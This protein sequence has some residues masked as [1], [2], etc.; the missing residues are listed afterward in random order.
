MNQKSLYKPIV[1]IILDGWGLT[2]S[3]SG[4]FIA[5]GQPRNFNY[6]WRNYPHQSLKSLAMVSSDRDTYP[7]SEICHTII[8]AGRLV[9][10]ISGIIS[11]QIKSGEFYQNQILHKIALNIFNAKTNLHLVGMITKAHS[12]AELTHLQALLNYFKNKGVK[13]VYLHGILD[14]VDTNHNAGIGT[15]DWLEKTLESQ[16]LGK[17]ATLTGRGWIEDGDAD[18]RQ[19]RISAR[20]LFETNK[21]PTSPNPLQAIKNSY[22]NH[23]GDADFSP[24]LMLNFDPELSRIK[25]DD[26]IIFFNFNGRDISEYINIISNYNKNIYTLTDYSHLKTQPIFTTPKVSPTL[27]EVISKNNLKIAKITESYKEK[28]L[29]YDFNG[30]SHSKFTGEENFILKSYTSHD[31][32]KSPQLRL[33]DVK[34][35]VVSKIVQGNFNLIVTNLP[36]VDICG[37]TGNSQ[38]VETAVKY[39]D[40]AI[41]EIVEKTLSVGGC[42]ILTADHGLAEEMGKI[43]SFTGQLKNFHTTNP[44]PFILINPDNRLDQHSLMQQVDRGSIISAMMGSDYNLADI[45]PTILELLGL[46][47]PAEMTGKSLLSSLNKN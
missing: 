27:S 33:Y 3:W 4:N 8:G 16:N 7:D 46:A 10:P 9:L 39:V 31:I 45:A 11:S 26:S 36:N 30:Y 43:S 6:Y 2:P 44:V 12:V 41:A 14:G 23:V 1:L 40:I 22:Q 35:M 34:N 21:I 20:A 32:N 29:I 5:S 47:I 19:I 13:N 38:V 37:H 15:I 18:L 24:T 28:N 42:A 17:I 25:P